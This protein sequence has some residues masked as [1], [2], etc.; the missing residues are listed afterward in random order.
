[1]RIAQILGTTVEALFAD[2][3]PSFVHA[4][5]VD[6]ESMQPGERVVVAEVQGRRIARSVRSCRSYPA[7][8]GPAIGWVDRIEPDSLLVEQ[9]DGGIHPATLIAGCDL[10]LGLLSEHVRYNGKEVPVVWCHADNRRALRQLADG[11]VHAAAVHLPALGATQSRGDESM[12]ELAGEV[13]RFHFA[14]WQLGWVIRRGNPR[15]FHSAADLAT[16]RLRIVS[17]PVGSGART[18]LDHL[19]GEQG[20][21]ALDV[22]GSDHVVAGHLEVAQAVD[23]GLA[24]VG[25]SIGSAAAMHGLDFVPI[26]DEVCELWVAGSEE[27]TEEVQRILETLQTSAFQKDL[28]RFGPYDVTD[29][30]VRL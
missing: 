23:V 9:P 3:A 29:T 7:V 21:R 30:G 26:Q 16:G 14:R 22:P 27:R 28:S 24:D 19:L 25:I 6:G 17:R 8:A 20:V 2:E 10:G 13:M 18:L 11:I 12:P 15:G 5:G 4:F 1:M